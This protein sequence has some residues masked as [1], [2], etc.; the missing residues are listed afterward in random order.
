MDRIS[1]EHKDLSSCYSLGLSHSGT[2]GLIV[3]RKYMGLVNLDKPGKLLHKEERTGSKHDIAEIQF[4]LGSETLCAVASGKKVDLNLKELERIQCL[5]FFQV[6]L[7]DWRSEGGGLVEIGSLKRHGHDITDLSF[8]EQETNIITTCA[9]DHNIHIWDIRNSRKPATTL[10]NMTWT[11]RV[12]II[13][14]LP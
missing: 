13:L 2:L 3:G 6:D 9:Y 8:H 5:L 1:A 10:S 12:R 11:S 7:L 14:Y 4:S